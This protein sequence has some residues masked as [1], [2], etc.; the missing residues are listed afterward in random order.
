[1]SSLTFETAVV[2]C[3]G[4]GALLSQWLSVCDAACDEKLKPV[5]VCPQT[6]QPDV[7][8]KY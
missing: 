4:L 7:G 3:A 6:S 2:I 8:A 5:A 1:M